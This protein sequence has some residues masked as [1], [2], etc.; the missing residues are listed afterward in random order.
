MFRTLLCVLAFVLSVPALAQD[1]SK[2]KSTHLI[3]LGM[4][5][6][7]T[8]ADLADRF[9][10]AKSVNLSWEIMAPSRFTYGIEG[11]VL[12]GRDV[13]EPNLGINLIN[14]NGTVTGASGF[15][16]V[17]D[18]AFFG[19]K[20]QFN[21]GKTWQLADSPSWM[22]VAKVGLGFVEHKINFDI[23]MEEVPQLT[24][25]YLKGY[26]RLTNG[27]STELYFGV[28]HLDENRLKNFYFGFQVMPAFTGGRRAFNF[29]TQTLPIEN[30]LDLL[31]GVKA[32]WVLPIYRVARDIYYYN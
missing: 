4:G 5:L 16:A 6:H 17:V 8:G 18:P 10:G 2:P 20:I 23:S 13:V 9:G 29:D 21:L 11:G 19:Y 31:Y 26:D 15:P 1:D 25:E 27:V 22:W 3:G 30:R 24:G 7:L 12:F 32:G 14:T 28:M